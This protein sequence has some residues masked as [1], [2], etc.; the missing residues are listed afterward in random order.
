MKK[1]L[2]MIKKLKEYI[3]KHYQWI[4]VVLLAIIAILA[5]ILVVPWGIGL[6]NRADLEKENNSL[7]KTATFYFTPTYTV[8]TAD[9]LDGAECQ[10]SLSSTRS[11]AFR[12]FLGD[13]IF[14]PCFIQTGIGYM[15][16]PSKP[17]EHNR[18]LTVS[19]LTKDPQLQESSKDEA[20]WY[21]TLEGGLNCSYVSGITDTVADGRIDYACEDE[22]WL[23]LPLNKESDVFTI[24]CYKQTLGRI[25]LCNIKEAWY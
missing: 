22:T 23:S 18:I 11:D 5:T 15:D 19:K 3:Q 25:E 20:P 12:C 8:K 10:T 1:R 6:A 2:P 7:R 24:K 17:N 4:I 9:I 13:A 14:D 16:C 21:I